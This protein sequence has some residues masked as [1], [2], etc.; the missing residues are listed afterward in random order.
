MQLK[1]EMEEVSIIVDGWCPRLIDTVYEYDSSLHHC[2]LYMEE[3]NLD[4]ET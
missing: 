1:C 4:A 3:V 2:H